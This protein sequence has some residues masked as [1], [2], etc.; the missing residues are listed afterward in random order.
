L[1]RLIAEYTERGEFVSTAHTS[2]THAAKVLRQ[3]PSYPGWLKDAEVFDLLRKAE[4]AGRLERVTYK[5]S[6]RHERERWQV[7]DAGR[8]DAATAGTA[9]TSQSTARAAV[10]P[11]PCGDCGDS[12]P[13]GMGGNAAATVAA[14]GSPL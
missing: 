8:R 9:G 3:E 4:R 13:G 2:R 12:P 6:D 10:P 11:V 14:P 5:A 1:L 7:T